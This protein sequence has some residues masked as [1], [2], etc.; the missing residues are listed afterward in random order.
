MARSE[1]LDRKI[2]DVNQTQGGCPMSVF[3][4]RTGALMFRCRT[5][6]DYHPVHFADFQ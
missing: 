1:L 3:A 5:M 4:F 2:F 6:T